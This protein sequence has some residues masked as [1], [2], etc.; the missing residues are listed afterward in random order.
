MQEALSK[1]K[2]IYYCHQTF[3]KCKNH[4]IYRHR[5]KS[6]FPS[7][8]PWKALEPQ[9]WVEYNHFKLMS[10]INWNVYNFVLQY[11]LRPFLC[12]FCISKLLLWP[13]LQ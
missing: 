6:L 5:S 4:F 12:Q 3:Y 7:Y 1:R 10:K 2:V 11:I 8:L 13:L 9:K